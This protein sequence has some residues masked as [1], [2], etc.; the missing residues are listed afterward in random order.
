MISDCSRAADD[1]PAPSL[2]THSTQPLVHTPPLPQCEVCV[3]VPVRNEADMVESTLTAL[4]HQID[5]EG[6]PLHPARYEVIVLANNCSDDSAAIA[7]RFALQHP[8]LVLHVVERTLPDS[9]AYIGWVRKQ[10]MDEAYRRLM[11]LGHQ[12]GVIASTDGDTR[13]ASNWI[14]ATLHEIDGGADAVGGR[15]ITDRR[16]RA[17]LTPYARACHLREVGYR[18]L[19]AELEAYLDPDP[20]D[21]L[22]RHFQHYGASLAVTA[23]MYQQ[24]GGLPPVKTSED[25]AL[26]QALVRVNA[27]FRHSLLVRV[28]TSARQT[29]RAHGGLANQLDTWTTMGQQQQP[30]LVEPAAA[31]AVRLYAHHELKRLWQRSLNGYP[32][33]SKDMGL[34][35]HGLGV[36]RNWLIRAM[37]QSASLGV[38]FE[39]IE[40]QREEVWQQRWPFV[41]V[42]QAIHDLRCLLEPLRLQSDNASIRTKA[43]PRLAIASPE[44]TPPLP[45]LKSA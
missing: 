40:Q 2:H 34:T 39:Q 38:L 24:A 10:L 31:I 29:G 21:S 33:N 12:R 9:N 43:L 42:E 1:L 18:F 14:A 45:S 15:I 6:R 30:F 28:T 3:I 44:M 36:D 5:L 23:E 27:R 25:V 17:A 4:T 35:A 16:D 32:L 13:V 37:S 20:F 22:P 7:R 11:L 41:R 19:V 26:Y 8:N